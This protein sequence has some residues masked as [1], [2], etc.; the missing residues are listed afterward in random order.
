[1]IS[2]HQLAVRM[3]VGLALLGAADPVSAEEPA[4]PAAAT[5]PV[6][7]GLQ[8]AYT[9]KSFGDIKDGDV[10]TA[11]FPVTNVS[12][13]VINITKVQPSCGCTTASGNPTSIAS[14]ATETI[15]ISFNSSGRL[16]K[17]VKSTTVVTDDPLQAEYR[18]TFDAN[19]T[20]EV[21][22]PK[23]V[24][25]FGVIEEGDSITQ[26]F[27]VISN[28]PTPLA[29][30]RVEA[31]DAS[32]K[33]EKV[34]ERPRPAVEGGGV[35][36][37]FEITSTGALP[38]GEFNGQVTL[39]TDQPTN[40]VHYLTLRG[41]VVG[42]FTHSPNRIALVTEKGKEIERRISIVSRKGTTFE[43]TGTKHD[44]SVPLEFSVEQNEAKTE[45]TIT[46]KFNTGDI[47]PRS[48]TG[49]ATVDIKA[50]DGRSQS[51]VVPV[52]LSVRPPRPASSAPSASGS[53]YPVQ[54]PAA[55]PVKQ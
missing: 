36:H 14:G 27:S 47:E 32:L 12:D 21:F 28:L 9:N 52:V 45:A 16:G 20:A 31:S 13:R 3:V 55:P 24:I 26:R 53:R 5:A 8:F 23:R 15:K 43:I 18:L 7:T 25:D 19:V 40:P 39:E 46:T 50:K 34:S 48:Y 2:L 10:V 33:V 22:L 49:R 54:G 4:A 29:F 1:M 37:V 44:L 41:S 17:N 11:E 51:I 38:G 6:K 35:E 42:E 30:K